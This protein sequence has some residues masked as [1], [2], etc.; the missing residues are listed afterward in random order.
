M[1]KS[2]ILAAMS[3]IA[4]TAGGASAVAAQS[5]VATFMGAKV[6][7]VVHHSK[8][9]KVLYSQNS[10]GD[11]EYL[12]SQN[13]TSAIATDY[14]DQGADDFIV[15]KGKTWIV[16]EV[17]VTGEGA[18]SPGTENVFFYKDKKGV[19]GKLVKGGSF[20]DLNG[21]GYSN[22]QIS[23]GKGVKLK[24]GHYWVGVMVNCAY[25]NCT[26]WGW[27][28]TGTIHNDPAQWEQ[29]G[30]GSKSGCT[31]WG[32]LDRCVGFAGDFMFEL[33]GKSE[34]KK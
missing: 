28:I 27:A 3:A 4:L 17:D 31:S 10:N 6:H 20:T 24:A 1:S 26:E 33:Q 23:L 16:T 13:Y 29:P 25:Y 21:T 12:D 14:A 34:T 5:P 19:P 15:P 30:N 11:G 7:G 2:T 32:T 22:Y 9:A 18:N 8:G